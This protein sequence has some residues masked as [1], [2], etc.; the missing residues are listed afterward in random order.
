[1]S[2]ISPRPTK[3]GQCPEGAGRLDEAVAAYDR[4][5]RC[6]PDFAAATSTWGSHCCCPE[7]S[8]TAGREYEWRLRGAHKHLKPRDCA[9]PQWRGED[10]YGR[11]ILLHAEQGLGD[12]IQ[13]CRYAALLAAR[14]GRVVLEAPRPLLRLLSGL[15]GVDQLIAAGDPLPAFDVHCPLMSLPLACGTQTRHD[16]GANSVSVRK[17]GDGFLL[18]GS[19][20]PQ[21]QAA[22]WPGV[23]RWL[24]AQSTRA[25]ACGNMTLQII[26]QL[27][28]PQLDFFSLQKGEPAESELLALQDTL[29]PGGNFHNV[30]HDLKDFDDTAGLIEA[31]DLV[32][33]VD[34]STVHLAGALGKPVW[35]LNRFDSCWR[36][37][38]QRDDSPWYPTLRL[39]RQP[40][41][42]DWQSVIQNVA[43][44]L[45]VEL[46]E[47]HGVS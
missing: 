41:R 42:G 35:L 40:G 17:A 25:S 37:L 8:L 34:T 19:V 9:A 4:A 27:N 12:T 7:T 44:A 6:K 28:H 18:A 32:I 21:N 23:E 39:F 3:S 24:S 36:W 16:P 10:L 20:G 26:A 43:R 11:T 15:K 30:A 1:M 5:I 22:R 29:W 31:L 33:G 2:R 14:G 47:R 45:E 13:F 46:V 38:E